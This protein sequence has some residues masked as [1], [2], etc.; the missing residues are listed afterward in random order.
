MKVLG[1]VMECNPFHE[2]HRYLLETARKKTGA[3]YC[4]VILSGDYVQ[5]GAP[6]ITD[7]YDRTRI[8]LEN[9]ADLV[10]ELPL[11]F[12][13]SSAEYFAFGSIRLLEQIGVVTDLAFGSESGDLELL[14]HY[15]EGLKTALPEGQKNSNS[16]SLQR[17]VSAASSLSDLGLIPERGAGNDLLAAHYL[18]YLPD[19]ITPHAVARI[20]VPSAS[21]CRRVL[22]SSE[23]SS[24]L[25]CSQDFSQAL[26]VRLLESAGHL[27]DYADVSVDLAN[28]IMRHLPEFTDFDSFTALLKSKDLTYTRISRSLLHI[29]LGIRRKALTEAVS[30]GHLYYTRVLGLNSTAGPLIS[31]IRQKL[32][33]N[34]AAPV[35]LMRPSRD[36]AF[37]SEAGRQMLEEE[38]RACLLYDFTLKQ[39]LHGSTD[40]CSIQTFSVRTDYEKPVVIFD[41]VS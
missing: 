18:K 8:L 1:I 36:Q 41:P 34:P 25:L 32:S 11:Y 7:K 40:P 33:E 6:A 24:R 9:G 23:Q 31:A 29:L 16:L 38:I 22:L 10:L 37:L 26:L 15:G 19:S 14:R 3:D 13:C 4:V 27:T 28:K 12:A 20:R 17:G 5:R 2:G 39:K 21:E 30:D 35:L